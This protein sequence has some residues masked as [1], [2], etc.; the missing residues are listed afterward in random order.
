[1]SHLVGSITGRSRAQSS[2]DDLAYAC[3]T[4]LRIEADCDGLAASVEKPKRKEGNS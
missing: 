3:S 4:R 2:G 1:M